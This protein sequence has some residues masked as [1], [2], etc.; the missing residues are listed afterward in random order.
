M[1]LVLHSRRHWFSW[2][3]TMRHAVPIWMLCALI[4]GLA[5]CG[6]GSGHGP[7]EDVT[8]NQLATARLSAG[9]NQSATVG[10]D[11]PNPLVAQ[12]LNAWAEPIAGQVVNFRVT[13][14]GGSVFAGAAASDA[15][16]FVR[17]RWTLG[18]VS[19]PQ[20]IEVRSVDPQGAG[21]AYATFEAVAVADVAV[22]VDIAAGNGQTAAQLQTLPAF[23]KAVLHDRYGNPVAGTPVSF[24]AAA[25]SVSPSIVLSDVLG[26]ASAQ[27]TLGSA[28]GSQQLVASVP[29][30][31]A[32]SFYATA[33]QAPPGMPVSL[34]MISGDA[35]TIAQ[36]FAV[37]APLIVK[38]LDALGNGVPGVMVDFAAAPGSYYIKQL[39]VETNSFGVASRSPYVHAAGAQ[40]VRASVA[41][42]PPVDFSVNVAA[43][44][45][46]FDGVYFVETRLAGDTVFVPYRFDQ[47]GAFNEATGSILFTSR[48]GTTPDGTSDNTFYVRGTLTLDASSRVTGSGTYEQSFRMGPLFVT[49]TWN[50]GIPT[51]SCRE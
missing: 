6:G 29:S 41:G 12:L 33:V 26:E 3:S 39:A 36:H 40:Q 43:A 49:G 16:G 9:N 13:L 10:T 30:G 7:S 35:Q 46:P 1:R 4:A 19:G 48:G 20:R 31:Q 44:G 32:A 50:C 27:W 5:A 22:K 42:L 45:R 47:V 15:D 11:L 37:P 17:E 34:Q 51:G 18:T 25:G 28:I 23:V 2:V 38:V 8:R 24:N 14:G 21:V